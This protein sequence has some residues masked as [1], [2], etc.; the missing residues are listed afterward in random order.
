MRQVGAL[1]LRWSL[2]H[3]DRKRNLNVRIFRTVAPTYDF[4]TR[5]LSLNGDAG[6]KRALLASLPRIPSPRCIDLACGTGDLSQGLAKR[7]PNGTIIGID[8]S[9]PMLDEARRRSRGTNVRYEIRDMQN[10]GLPDGSI[11]IVTGGYAL[12]NA[13]DV[14]A[15]LK[16][17]HRILKP[18]GVASFLDFSRPNAK[19]AQI[20]VSLLLWIWCG[21]W[22][23]VLHGRPAIYGY[24]PASLSLFPTVGQLLR[25]LKEFGFDHVERTSFYGG[26]TNLV[27][28][29]KMLPDSTSPPVSA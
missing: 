8:I 12:R 19:W 25:L 1:R 4:L 6:W 9:A 10:T 3:A 21:F 24:I 14:P 23:L 2:R 7:Y 11:D 27:T 13:P 18:G 16:E 17:V 28:A 26:L 22:G 29:T 5:A 20:S 15:T